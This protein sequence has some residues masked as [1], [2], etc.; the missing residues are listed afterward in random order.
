MAKLYI[1]N[2]SKRIVQFNYPMIGRGNFGIEIAPGQQK[3]IPFDL[4]K[5][6][7]DAIVRVARVFG[8][9]SADET[10]GKLK[11]RAGLVYRVDK[12]I[13]EKDL[14]DSFEAN[15]QV[16][17]TVAAEELQNSAAAALF[18]AEDLTSGK[19]Q[20]EVAITEGDSVP[21]NMRETTKTY[22]KKK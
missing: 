15:E 22:A 18:G 8:A 19:A 17:A 14:T 16:A 11:N 10:G 3:R 13:S 7:L 2:P 9:L 12:P 6:E 20:V 4:Q 1:G 21:E 5:E